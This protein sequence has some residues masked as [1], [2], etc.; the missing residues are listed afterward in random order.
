M[1]I[2]DRF[3][4]QDGQVFLTGME[5]IIRLVLEKQRLDQASGHVNQTYFTGYEGSPLGGL[6][7]KLVEQLE[8]L[9][10]QGRTVHQFGI[11][12]KTAASAVLGSQFAASGDVDAFWYGKAHGTMW[13]PDEMWLA[14]LSGTGKRGAIVLLSGEDHR[15][16]SSVSPGASDWVLRSSMIPTFYPA[17]VEEI[18]RLGLHA[19]ALSRHTGVVTSLKLTTPVCDAA[20]TVDLRVVRPEIVLPER[21]YAK[22]FNQIVMATGALPMQRQLLEEKWPLVEAYIRSNDLNRIIDADAGGEIGIIATGKSYTDVRQALSY[23]GLRVPILH[24]A[25]AYPL[26]QRVVREF[27][28]DLR[29][30]YVVEEPGPFVEEAVKAA[31]WNTGVEAVYGQYDQE[32]QP[33]IPSYGEVDP[34]ELAQKLGPLLA[35]EVGRLTSLR[36]VLDRVYPAVPRVT[37]MSCGGCPYNSFRD[38]QEKPGGAIGC[39]SIRAIEAYGTGVLYIPTM[40]AG[41]AIYSGWSQFNDHQHI[42][43]YLGDGSYFHSGRGA[44]QSCIHGQV[45]ITFLLLYNGA[46]ALTGGQRPGGQR[47]VPDVVQELLGLGVVQV[48]VVCEDPTRYRSLSSERIEIYALEDHAKALADFK[49]VG[50]TTVLILDKECATEKGRRRRRQGLM[51]EEYVLIDEAICEG[52]GDCYAQSEGCAALYSVE[53][54]FGEKTQVRQA[55]CAQDGLCID[56]ECPSFVILKPAKGTRLKRRRPE[57]LQALP[58]P[59]ACAIDG[60]YSI[61]AMGRGGT[62]VVTISHLIAYAAMMDGKYVYLSNNTGL[63]QKGGPVEAP[64]LISET[65]QPVFNRLFPGGVDLYLGFDL[66]RSAEPEN[67]KYAS[68]ERTR[69]MVST[70]EIAN[71]SMNRNPRQQAFPEAAGLQALIEQYTKKDNLYLDTYCLAEEL[72]ADTLYANMILLGAAYQAGAVPL[73][74]E[75]IERAIELNARAVENNIQAFRW[76]RLSVV[77]PGRVERALGTKKVSA[78]QALSDVKVR[79]ATTAKGAALLDE[80]Q[81]VVA[82][83]DAEGQRELCTRLAELCDYQDEA[84]ARRYLS[85]IQKVWQAERGLPARDLKLTRA[86]VRGLFKIMAYK[87]E[88]EVARLATA[89]DS[90]QRMRALFDG[91]VEIVRQLHPPTLRGILRKKIGFAR[92]LRPSLVLLSRLKYLRGTVFDIFARTPA[93]KMERE[94]VD[95]YCGLVELIIAGLTGEKYGKAI[96]IAELPDSIR[97]YEH[98]KEKAAIAA[99]K[100]GQEL[101]EALRS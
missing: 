98:V 44:I 43:Q 99:K 35:A 72:F 50:G 57:A 94:L 26:D 28:R 80:A 47:P 96:E 75:S 64:I 3:Q 95:W 48:G 11:N 92:G 14:N 8:T 13:I 45:N 61:F 86:V 39:S 18:I 22:Q 76:G 21:T 20:S 10:R 51:P 87:D 30:L 19:I 49:R 81:A 66:L 7:L 88:Y 97:G 23:L 100:R 101:V 93:R 31:L 6:D 29:R 77:D 69:A 53:T 82:G 1:D 38:L 60:T 4:Q 62:G 89:T 55:S 71:A 37:P 90:E 65:E 91:E 41:G 12:E 32:G 2:Q 9:N 73:S 15:S 78:Q 70:A 24:L 67:L 54:E 25:I 83:L 27:A 68:P 42:Y 84:Y 52:C 85:W 33:F 79:L 74:S 56:G 5:A 40:G 16:K 17:N 59:P 63:A 34:E 36:A 46:V 58:E